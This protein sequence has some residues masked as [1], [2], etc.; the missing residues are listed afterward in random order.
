LEYLQGSGKGLRVE[1]VNDRY[2]FN[3]Y[4]E[5][6]AD[7]W[8]VTNINENPAS[9]KSKRHGVLLG[10][11]IVFYG[12]MVEG[13]WLENLLNSPSFEMISGEDA[14]S[15][16]SAREVKVVFRSQHAV[17]KANTILGG[18]LW[19]SP[20]KFWVLNRYDVEI[21]ST[22]KGRGRAEFKYQDLAGGRNRPSGSFGRYAASCV[23]R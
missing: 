19:F 18:T 10:N 7:A 23:G 12:I 4:K 16:Q 2:A 11:T 9:T 15:S 8:G 22:T 6:A 17:D 20:D 21:E 3:L 13:D 1:S 14:A 5:Q